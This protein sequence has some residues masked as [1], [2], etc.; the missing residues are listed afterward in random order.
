MSK[1]FSRSALAR[2]TGVSPDTLRHYERKGVLPR[3]PRT[4]NG[5]RCYP[6]EAVAR[7]RLVRRAMAVGF[8]LGELAR[9]LRERDAGGVPCR[10]T[11]AILR[12]RFGELEQRIA[13][14]TALRDE[15]RDVLADWN[16]RL[17]GTAP[18]VQARLLD[19]LAG[20]KTIDEAVGVQGERRPLN[21]REGHVARHLKSR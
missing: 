10:K 13:D 12:V 9:L 19:A 1:S 20:R 18:G 17:A 2:L 6:E 14:L 11:H 16:A 15:L 21:S 7:V 3:P 4:A 5:Y 8:T